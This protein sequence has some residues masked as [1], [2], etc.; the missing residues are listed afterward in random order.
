MVEGAGYRVVRTVYNVPRS[1]GYRRADRLT[2]GLLREFLAV[3][4]LVLG[5]K[6]DAGE[7]RQR[8]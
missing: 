3:Q 4:I 1:R 7:E 8:R 6:G 5:Q 2:C